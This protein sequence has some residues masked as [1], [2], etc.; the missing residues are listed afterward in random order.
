MG[1]IPLVVLIVALCA[2][3]VIMFFILWDF[4]K[5]VSGFTTGVKQRQGLIVTIANDVVAELK[6]V[7]SN[8]TATVQTIV[9][10][11]MAMINEMGST[12]T[13][14]ISGVGGSITNLINVFSTDFTGLWNNLVTNVLTFWQTTIECL[15]KTF[16]AFPSIVTYTAGLTFVKPS[17][18]AST[19]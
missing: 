15:I 14:A 13:S 12:I 6:F 17:V 10:G 8:L 18:C 7:F 3:A 19:N 4:N 2:F 11:L 5:I 9:A 1:P 16:V